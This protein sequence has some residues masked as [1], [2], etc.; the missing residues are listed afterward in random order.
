MR[1][2]DLI[3]SKRDGGTLGP[4]EIRAFVDGVTSGAWPDY[5][6]AAM[7]MAITLRGM[8]E[9][10]TLA[11]TGAMVASGRRLTRASAR[12][13]RVDK[14]ST[15]G[16]GDKVSLV[17]APM[18]AACGLHVPMMS[19][20]AL[21]HTGGTLDKLEAIPG[22]RVRLDEGEIAGV[23]QEAGCCIVGQTEAIA[24]ADRRLYALRDVTATVESVPLIVASIL[25]K[26]LAED[27]DALVIDV[28]CGRGTFMATEADATA[29]ASALVGIANEGGVRTE[30][31]ITSMDSPLGR[32]VGNALEVREAIEALGGGGPADLRELC[33]M[34][35]ARLLVLSGEAPDLAVARARA[36]G[37]LTSGA[38]LE[39]F[40]AMVASQGGDVRVIDEPDRLPCAPRHEVLVAPAGG[41]LGDLDAG[42]IGRAAMALGAGRSRADE[43]IDAGVGVRLHAVPGD[44]VEAGQP[45]LE[46][47]YSDPARLPG[48]RGLAASAIA[49]LPERPAIPPLVRAHIRP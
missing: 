26:K 31:V 46:L 33:E 11:L 15:G 17:L 8:T 38:A 10:E 27:L 5:Q 48:A 42:R 47:R 19:G 3:R 41:W 9:A 35:C 44:R 37:T 22:L 7:L 45:V 13:S 34:L 40:G 12:P 29:L 1:A 21:G 30:A 14:H 20:R 28:K 25:S 18:L 16:V 6:A 24:P 39:R 43:R 49:V 36:G 4:D 32:T 2:V 23:L